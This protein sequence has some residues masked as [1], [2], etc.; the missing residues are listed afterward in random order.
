LALAIPGLGKIQIGVKFLLEVF[1]IIYFIQSVRVISSEQQ[2]SMYLQDLKPYITY[3][4]A[5]FEPTISCSGG[6][7]EDKRHE[8]Y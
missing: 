6:G 7:L 5:G 8:K 4:L 2:Q 1:L 3:L